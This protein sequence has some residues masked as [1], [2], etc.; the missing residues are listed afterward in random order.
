MT[1]DEFRARADKD[2]LDEITKKLNMN[3]DIAEELDSLNITVM[4]NTVRLE[5]TV[6][7][8]ELKENIQDV[9]EDIP[10]V[11][12]VINDLQIEKI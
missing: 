9:I 1:N 6:S 12:Q 10:G 3:E 5:G 7:S 2:I 4:D 8:L 11:A